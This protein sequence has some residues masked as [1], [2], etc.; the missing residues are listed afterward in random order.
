MFEDI[1]A[2][3]V[4]YYWLDDAADGGHCQYSVYYVRLITFWQPWFPCVTTWTAHTSHVIFRV[5]PY[6][7]T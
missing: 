1:N 4:I 7:H 6:L 5:T 2:I 3:C